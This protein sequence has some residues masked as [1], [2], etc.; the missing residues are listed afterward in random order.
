MTLKKLI[1]TNWVFIGLA[2]FSLTTFVACDK[3]DDMMDPMLDSTEFSY[4]FHN[5]QTVPSAPY[6]GTHPSDLSASLAL[7]ELEN[8]N[9]KITVTIENSLDGEM[10]AIHAHD[11]A[12]PATTPN[13]T[14][15]NET[16]NSDIL[17]Q[18]AEGNGGTVSVSQEATMSY[19]DLINSYEGF[20]VIHD[21]L[22]PINTAD[23]STYLIVGSFAREQG[24]SDYK[25]Q[26]FSYD[27]NTGQ[28]EPTFA[29]EG[30]HS[31]DVTATIRVDELADDQSR[32]VISIMNTMDGEMYATHAHDMADPATTP[33]GTP[34]NETPNG[35]VFAGGISGNGGTAMGVNVSSFSYDD[36]LNTYDGF[37]VVHDPLQAIDTTDPTTYLVLGVFAR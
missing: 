5:G 14:P 1:P 25:S 26:T 12:D 29:Y 18:M 15:Y 35:D 22:Q 10:Y 11:A 33:N 2:A 27:F 7:E 9:T 34:Y 23:I 16:P 4:D 37:F 31:D 21:P 3:E 8:G 24:D 6:A 17:T 32:I 20:F 13:G 19:G 36:I 30:T 28:L